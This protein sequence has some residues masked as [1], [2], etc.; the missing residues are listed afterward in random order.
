MLSECLCFPYPELEFSFEIVVK[1][2]Q[3]V[4]I[5]IILNE[6]ACNEVEN[7]KIHYMWL[8]NSVSPWRHGMAPRFGSD[9]VIDDATHPRKV[10]KNILPT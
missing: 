9:V 8:E 7:M 6:I 3:K 5:S 10:W 2:V 4:I 1:S